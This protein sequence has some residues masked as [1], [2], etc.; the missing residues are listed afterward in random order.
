[1]Q[2]TFDTDQSRG[3]FRTYYF[4]LHRGSVSTPRMSKDVNDNLSLYEELKVVSEPVRAYVAAIFKAEFPLL[5]ERYSEVADMIHAKFPHLEAAFYPFASYCVN[6]S[7]RGVVTLPHIDMQNLGPGLCCVIPFGFFDAALDCKLII[8]E[9]GFIF[10]VSA[11]TPI[12]FPSALF[13]HYNSKLVTMGM[14]G[15]IVAWTGA[16]LFQYVDLGCRSVGD[17]SKEER[18]KYHTALK[19]SVLMGFDKFPRK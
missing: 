9:L 11:G 5:S 19:D 4:S 1:M 17:L 12:F 7:A 8:E 14:R 6:V 3:A 2:P 15:S 18:N 13:T 16:S 10:Q